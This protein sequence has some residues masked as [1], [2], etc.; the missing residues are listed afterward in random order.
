MRLFALSITILVAVACAADPQPAANDAAAPPTE[1]PVDTDAVTPV[2]ADAVDPVD[3]DA[4][5]PI[6]LLGSARIAKV[7]SPDW[8]RV[9]GFTKQFY[10][11]ELDQLYAS[12]SAECK[13]EF[14]MQNLVD[15]RDKMLTEFGEEVEIVATRKEENEGYHAYF[16]AARFSGDERLIEVAFVIAPDESIAGLFIT[17]DRTAQHPAQ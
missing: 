5:D 11:G 7:V 12:F 2:D 10:E 4:V 17:P 3:T 16:R 8:A 13:E 14:S 1:A 9:E 6:N 15:L